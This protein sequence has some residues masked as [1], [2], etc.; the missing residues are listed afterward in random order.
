[1]KSITQWLHV[2]TWRSDFAGVYL[3]GFPEIL[4]TPL[5]FYASKLYDI[6]HCYML[7]FHQH[8]IL[9]TSSNDRT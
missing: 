5:K 6:L 8:P 4:E 2:E 3:Y 9:Q 7:P 1:M